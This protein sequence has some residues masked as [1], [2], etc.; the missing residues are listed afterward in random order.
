MTSTTSPGRSTITAALAGASP[1][2]FWLDSPQRPY[3]LPAL[4]GRR[5]ADLAVVGGGF[6]GLW[7][8]LLAKERD[9]ARQV[10]LVEGN[11]LGWAASGRNGGFCSASVTHGSANG[12]RHFP[13]EAD[14]LHRLGME[15]LDELEQTVS[16]YGIDCDFARTGSMSVATEPHQVSWLAAEEDEAAGFHYLDQEAVRREV[17]SPTYLAGLW[18]TQGSALVDP[19]RLVWGL[20]DACLRHGVEIF[21]NT[22][23][24]S[25]DADR[26]AVTLTTDEGRL[27]ADRVVLGT[28]AFSSLLRRTHLHTV[29]VYDYA[30]MTEPL[31]DD[32]I[33]AI[34]WQNHQGL[35]DV[36][37]RFHYYRRTQDN[38]I[39][40]GG[41]DAIYHYG[42]RVRAKYDQRPATFRKLAGHFF[43][44][45]PQLTDIK[46]SHQWGGAIDTCSRFCP[47]FATAADGRIAYS[48]GYTGLGVGATRFGANVLLDLLSG[49]KTELTELDMVQKRPIPFPPEPLAW[50]SIKLTTAA[51]I[52]ADR[53][54]GRRGPWLKLLDTFG[55]GF[56]S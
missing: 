2:P 13:Q 1:T 16:R 28:N 21:E 30:L 43:E 53:R 39:L 18:D 17:N 11:T 36:S 41:F 32:Q 6:T 24:R 26:R 29:P 46:F 20:K 44:T 45:F 7:A 4:Q 5:T 23:A 9:P 52:R 56:D 22:P 34:G 38:R 54:E 27:V 33:A 42:R 40:F 50:I 3:P 12:R 15:N 19:A 47:F 51:L 35:D 8:A 49:E 10:T 31:N 55:V 48:A 25:L 14:T 37:N